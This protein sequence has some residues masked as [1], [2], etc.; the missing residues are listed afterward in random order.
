MA[1]VLQT[2]CPSAKQQ[3]CTNTELFR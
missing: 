1:E 2:K 3:L